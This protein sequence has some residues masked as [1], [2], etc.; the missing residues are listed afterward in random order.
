[1]YRRMLWSPFTYIRSTNDIS[2]SSTGGIISLGLGAKGWSVEECTRRFEDLCKTA[3]TRRNFSGV[4]GIGWLIEN[5]H[6]SRYETQ[7]LQQ[8]LRNSFGDEEGDDYL[9]G[10]NNC[11]RGEVKVAVVAASTAGSVFV[12]SNYNRT[13][14]L[15]R[16]SIFVGYSGVLS[17]VQLVT[18]FRDRRSLMWN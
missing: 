9:F 10:V 17:V 15:K 6:H 8:V 16:K 4:P 11:E 1:M 12:L 14:D 3:F 18:F 7:P 13:S 2:F 5:H